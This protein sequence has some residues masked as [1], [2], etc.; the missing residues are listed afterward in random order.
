[1]AATALAAAA[2]AALI[3]LTAPDRPIAAWY[4]V[5]AVAALIMFRGAGIVIERG[6]K[7][8]GRVRRV[9]QRPI[10]RLALANL[11]RPGAPTGR[12]VMS[13]G[14]G[15]TVL[16]AIALVEGNLAQEIGTNLAEAAPEYFVIDIQP[17]QLAGF[18]NIVKSVPGAS[19]DQVPMLRGRITKL[20]GVSVENAKVAPDA[21][22]A[23]RSDRGLTYSA[24]VPRGSE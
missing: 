18:G 13:L 3:V 12:A 6:A 9:A 14:I 23:L 4:V 1:A 5:G 11:H 24:T 22:W 19:F 8:L 20:N 2:L 7:A 21:Q 15:L 16:V 17:D 10:L